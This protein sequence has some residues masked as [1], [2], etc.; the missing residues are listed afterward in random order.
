MNVPTFTAVEIGLY[1]LGTV[2]CIGN[3]VR[4]S[5]CSVG[6]ISDCIS[7]DGVGVKCLNGT[8]NNLKVKKEYFS[9]LFSYD[10]ITYMQCQIVPMMMFS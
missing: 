3:E 8:Y 2:Q 5:D 4:I 9:T 6:H 7:Y 1:S 10:Y